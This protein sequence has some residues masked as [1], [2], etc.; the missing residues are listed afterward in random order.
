MIFKRKGGKSMGVLT[1]QVAIIT[2]ASAGIGRASA[3]ALAAEGAR[4]VAVARRTDR[5]Q[6]LV[7]EIGSTGGQAVA[8]TGSVTDPA[9]VEAA[10]KAALDRFGRI[11]IL[12]NNA[13]TNVQGDRSLTTIGRSEF[14]RVVEVNLEAPYNFV[15]AVLPTMREHKSG[16][17]INIVSG[18][19]LMPSAMTGAAYCSSKFGLRALTGNINVEERKN[20]IRACAIFPG[21]VDTEILQT[22]PVQLT[23]EEKA[24]ILK[25]EDIAAAVTFAATL[26]P[27]ATV[28]EINIRPTV[29]R[30]PR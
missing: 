12:V 5:L 23:A 14:R 21:E 4:I 15:A 25:A 19:G 2:G 11:D 13:G 3:I 9:T 6:T 16:T 17:I 7:D 26:P 18:A 22:R 10:V 29:I 20:G 30:V 27:R 1:D 28:E 24:K 8:V